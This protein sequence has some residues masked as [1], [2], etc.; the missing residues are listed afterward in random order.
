[1]ARPRG[2]D[3]EL[4]LRSAMFE[5]WEK[6]YAQTT[7]RDLAAAMGVGLPSLYA[8]FGDKRRLFDEAVA[9]YKSCPDYLVADGLERHAAREGIALMLHR[10][11]VG[12]TDPSHP[13]G[14][15]LLN[16]PLLVAERAVAQ[17]AIHAFL[18]R[19]RH[20]LDFAPD[21]DPEATADFYGAVLRGLC[22]QARDGGSR[23]QLLRVSERAMAAWPARAR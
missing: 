15:L 3:R 10:A 14:C 13:R 19:R 7:I 8:A 1:M 17:R 23:A 5:F 12:Y 9:L 20:S 6:E 18:E 16:E 22:S 2:F 11:A 21:A 4:A